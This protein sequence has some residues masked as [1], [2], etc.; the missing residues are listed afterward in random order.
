MEMLRR[1]KMNINVHK[2]ER[3]GGDSNHLGDRKQ[4]IIFL[5]NLK[6]VALMNFTN[7]TS[8]QESCYLR[9]L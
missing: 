2:E 1:K 8:S 5:K 3:R 6:A 9:L 4:C 7:L